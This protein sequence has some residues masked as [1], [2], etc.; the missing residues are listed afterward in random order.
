MSHYVGSTA[1]DERI[2]LSHRM[3]IITKPMYKNS[4]PTPIKM[5][6]GNPGSILYLSSKRNV[7][8]APMII[9]TLTRD[10]PIKP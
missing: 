5:E 10:P 2:I 6:R 9:P 1:G 8:R 7:A 4:Q 3:P